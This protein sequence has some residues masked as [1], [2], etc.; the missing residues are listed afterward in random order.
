L[1]FVANRKGLN[2]FSDAFR[3]SRFKREGKG[4]EGASIVM[5]LV[6]YE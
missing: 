2:H 3:E 6:L 4:V 5:S 1:C